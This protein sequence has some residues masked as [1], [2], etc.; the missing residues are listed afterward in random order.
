M[1]CPNCK[2]QIPDGSAFCGYCGREIPKVPLCTRC[3]AALRP[4]DRFCGVC[5]APVEAPADTNKA[6]LT[7][8]EQQLAPVQ[9]GDLNISVSEMIAERRSPAMLTGISIPF[10]TYM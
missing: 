3:G 5:G 6:E 4:N 1:T 7:A 10:S 9:V 2:K 8:L